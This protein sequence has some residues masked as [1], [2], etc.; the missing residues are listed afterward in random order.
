MLTKRGKHIYIVSKCKK[1]KKKK[2]NQI[3]FSITLVVIFLLF[4]V[5]Y[6]KDKCIVA[7]CDK[8]WLFIFL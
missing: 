1:K 7:Q 8:S 6:V 4:S 5:H 3:N 2:L